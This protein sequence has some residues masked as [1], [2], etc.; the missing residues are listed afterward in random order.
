MGRPNHTHLPNYIN[1]NYTFVKMEER[2]KMRERLIEL[3]S[4]V[5]Y[6]GGLEEKLADHLIAEGVIV[7]PVKIGQKVYIIGLCDD[8]EELIVT[9]I[10]SK[11]N[12]YGSTFFRF[13]TD[14]GVGI[15]FS[16]PSEEIGKTVFLTKEEAEKALAERSKR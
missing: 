9:A 13:L 14:I 12:R 3:I 1:G 5:Q 6:M 8:I 10:F 7:P 15:D 4:K 11:H 2:Q 16:F